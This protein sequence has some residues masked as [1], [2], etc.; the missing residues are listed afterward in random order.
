MHNIYGKQIGKKIYEIYGKGPGETDTEESGYDG[1]IH[2]LEILSYESVGKQSPDSQDTADLAP[3]NNN[4]EE[5]TDSEMD[6]IFKCV[7]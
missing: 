5:Q 1:E 6:F 7:T 4:H 3:Y 2:L